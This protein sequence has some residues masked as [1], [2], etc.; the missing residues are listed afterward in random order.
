[1]W[2]HTKTISEVLLCCCVGSSNPKQRLR[3]TGDQKP[4][5]LNVA[6]CAG[7]KSLERP[8]NAFSF[9]LQNKLSI[10]WNHTSPPRRL[11]L[12]KWIINIQ[13]NTQEKNSTKNPTKKSYNCPSKWI[14]WKYNHIKCPRI[15]FIFIMFL[16]FKLIFMRWSCWTLLFFPD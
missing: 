10:P 14:I 11:H 15:I 6:N 2:R 3:K 1:M 7:F 9:L 16:F 5:C 8:T 13:Q 12:W 4:L